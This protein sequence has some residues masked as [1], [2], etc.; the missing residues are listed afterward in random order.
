MSEKLMV[1]GP[2]FSV[3]ADDKID[4][5]VPD[6]IVYFLFLTTL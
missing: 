6:L 1:I 3:I 4:L 2:T 5:S